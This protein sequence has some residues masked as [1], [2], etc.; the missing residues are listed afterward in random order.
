MELE[1]PLA[2]NHHP[3]CSPLC[4]LLVVEEEVVD[5]APVEGQ[6]RD[7]VCEIA[8]GLRDFDTLT[9]NLQQKCLYN[10]RLE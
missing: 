4:L 1:L 5:A 8:Y 2:S 9:F 10:K 7:K 3:L 6:L